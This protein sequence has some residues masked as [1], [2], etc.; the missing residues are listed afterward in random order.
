MNIKIYPA[1]QQGRLRVHPVSFLG[2]KFSD[3]R[4][5]MQASKATYDALQRTNFI[6]ESLLEETKAKLSQAGFT[7]EV[8][9][10]QPR[11]PA[12]DADERYAAQGIIFI[13]R[14]D[15]D[16]AREQNHVGFSGLDSDFGHKMAEVCKS[17]M[18][19]EKQWAAIRKLAHKYRKQI[20]VGLLDA[21]MQGTLP[22]VG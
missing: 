22:L 21:G 3:Y 20:K 4:S 10:A 17:G 11:R 13:A 6:T 5:A 2:D 7:V 9:T 1:D 8:I 18:A 12:K 16:Y 15:P 19:S 14:Q